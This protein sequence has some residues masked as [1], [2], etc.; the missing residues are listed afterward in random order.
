MT[1]PQGVK[2]LGAETKKYIRRHSLSALCA[3]ALIGAE[4]WEGPEYSTC[5]WAASIAT[6]FGRPN[7]PGRVN[8]FPVASKWGWPDRK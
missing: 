5:K 4:D 8:V 1:H 6:R 3:N 7:F 2:L